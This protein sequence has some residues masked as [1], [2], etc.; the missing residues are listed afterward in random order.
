MHISLYT[1]Q[2]T[3]MNDEVKQR[4]EG[5]GLKKVQM[6]AV[7]VPTV[8]GVFSKLWYCVLYSQNGPLLTVFLGMA[9]L[10]V[11]IVVFAKFMYKSRKH[12]Y[13]LRTPLL[14]QQHHC[15]IS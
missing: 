13:G 8:F 11:F 6:L 5:S 4:V 1:M 7:A 2:Y 15:Y 14:I 3:I 9:S 10:F 12:H